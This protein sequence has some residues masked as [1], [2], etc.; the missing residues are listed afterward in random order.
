MPLATWKDLVTDATDPPAVARFW[1][2]VLDRTTVRRDDGDLCLDGVRPA[3]RIWVDAVPERRRVKDRVH[4][5]VTGDR[6]ERIATITAAGGRHVRDLPGWTVFADPEGGEH[7]LFPRGDVTAL[8]VDARDPVRT[9]RWWAEVFGVS[10]RIGPE[11]L[12]RWLPVPDAPFDVWKFVGVPEPKTVKNRRHW[13]LW[14]DDVPALVDHGA[15]LLRAPDDDVS[16]HVLADP[17]GNEFCAFG[18]DLRED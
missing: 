1:A 3:E 18:S 14:C 15:T 4:L 9:A 6:D 8:V 13:D 2:R 5:D 10:P 16:W 7:C 12:P 11:G 17:E